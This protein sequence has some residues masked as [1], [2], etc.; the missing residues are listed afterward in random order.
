M[1]IR[2]L[3][4]SYSNVHCSSFAIRQPLFDGHLDRSRPDIA[5]RIV[6]DYRRQLRQRQRQE[7]Q[8][9][10]ASAPGRQ[11]NFTA[12][13]ESAL[14]RDVGEGSGDGGGGGRG[15]DIRIKKDI[16]AIGTL[17]NGLTLYRFKYLWGKTDLVGVMAQEVL[18]VEPRAVTTGLNGYYRVN[19][20][21]LGLSMMTFRQWQARF[22]AAQPKALA[23]TKSAN[24]PNG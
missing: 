1:P 11:F 2:C 19:Y 4:P 14:N 10:P 8:Q 6:A 23:I 16:A 12:D 13:P 9:R 5:L 21:M 15:S 24:L 3:L 7:R 18:K 20:E 22:G 17:P